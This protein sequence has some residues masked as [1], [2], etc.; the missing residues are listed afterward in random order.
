MFCSS[1][2][3]GATLNVIDFSFHFHSIFD[4]R[5]AFALFREKRNKQKRQPPQE[6]LQYIYICTKKNNKF[7]VKLI[8]M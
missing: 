1:I 2:F 5:S 8:D 6:C 3:P 4:I 7:K